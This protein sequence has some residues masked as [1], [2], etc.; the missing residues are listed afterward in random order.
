VKVVFN[1]GRAN[2]GRKA[3]R[4]GANRKQRAEEGRGG[5]KGHVSRLASASTRV[6]PFSHFTAPDG[7][8]L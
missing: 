6:L 8:G 4:E 2:K 3:Q 5:H 7:L 1:Q